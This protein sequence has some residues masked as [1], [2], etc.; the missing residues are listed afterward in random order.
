[1]CRSR[2]ATPLSV[3]DQSRD[4]PSV[5]E[6]ESRKCRLMSVE[7]RLN[8]TEMPALPPRGKKAAP[9]CPCQPSSTYVLYDPVGIAIPPPSLNAQ[10]TCWAAATFGIRRA[11][12]AAPMPTPRI[13]TPPNLVNRSRAS[14]PRRFRR[15]PPRP[16]LSHLTVSPPEPRAGPHRQ[17]SSS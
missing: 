1:P 3:S 12:T 14:R 15:T 9:S 7:L 16:P 11:S 6:R 2:V 4:E 5:A 10:R 13:P 17:G 8:S